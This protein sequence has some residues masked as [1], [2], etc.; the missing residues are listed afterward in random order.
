MT[1]NMSFVTSCLA[2]GATSVVG[3]IFH[4]S[5][6]GNLLIMIK[7]YELYMEIDAGRRSVSESLNSAQKWIRC[8][9]K[10]ILKEYLRKTIT[11]VQKTEKFQVL[12]KRL[13]PT[14]ALYVQGM[15]QTLDRVDFSDPI[16]WAGLTVWE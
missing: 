7:F 16:Y 3:S 12:L 6:L 15:I 5:G 8:A 9:S 11:D 13:G 4:T 10:T 1:N 2:S 14:L